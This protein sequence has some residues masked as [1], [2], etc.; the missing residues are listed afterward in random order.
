MSSIFNGDLDDF[1]L[2]LILF[3]LLVIVGCSC[4]N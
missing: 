2:V 1:T 4:D 3:I